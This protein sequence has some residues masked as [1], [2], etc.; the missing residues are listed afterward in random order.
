MHI[1][2]RCLMPVALSLLLAP[3]AASTSLRRQAT[4][5]NGHS[6]LCDRSFGNVTFVG[7]HDSYAVSSINP[8]ANQDKNVTQQLTDGI[9]MLQLQAHNQSG[10]IQLCH[11]S[12]ELLN[13]GTLADYLGSV[14]SWMDDN[15]NDVV[16]LL[17]VNSY[18]N[19]SPSSYDSVFKS[20]GLN[21]MAYAPPSASLPASGWPT[22]G[23]LISNGTRLVVFLTTQADFGTVPYLIDEFTNIWETAYDVTTTAFDCNVNRTNGDT[24]TQMYLINHFLDEDIAG[25]LVPDKSQAS[26]TNGVSGTGSLGQQVDTCVAQYNRDPNFMLVDFYEY[27]GGS[28][29]QVAA[30]ANGVT[31]SPTTPITTPSGSG[32]SSAS[33]S[34]GVVGFR[35]TRGHLCASLAVSVG[36]LAGAWSIF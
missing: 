24:S 34:N 32:S 17:I 25:I 3:F 36:M 2:I 19:I 5:C 27:G 16:S 6:E 33:G 11:T 23:S 8:A 13:G 30:T 14:K 35:V 21:T 7:A 18:D 28:V 12:C 31:Y 4:T 10:V 22:L 29:F 1:S 15:P 26:Q 20:A 9:R